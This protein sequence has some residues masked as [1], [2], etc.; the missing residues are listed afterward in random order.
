MTT[1]VSPV[2]K[3]RRIDRIEKAD[4]DEET[5]EKSRWVTAR[6]RCNSY[7]PWEG[8][9]ELLHSMVPYKDYYLSK[10]EKYPSTENVVMN[11][12]FGCTINLGHYLEMFPADFKPS[13][14]AA[15]IAHITDP[16]TACLL[17]H[18]GKAV[19]V[20]A[21]SI[22]S[23][24]LAAQKYRRQLV[25]IGYDTSFKGFLLQNRVC[26][27][28]AGHCIDLEKL[29]KDD[30]VGTVHKWDIFPGVL[31]WINDEDDPRRKIMFLIF[32]SGKFIVTGI[33]HDSEAHRAFD[34]LIPVLHRYYIG[35]AES[36]KKQKGVSK[37]KRL[38]SL[39]IQAIVRA[40]ITHRSSSTL[41]KEQMTEIINEAEKKAIEK[42]KKKKKKEEKEKEKEKEKK[43][44]QTEEEIANEL[45]QEMLSGTT[46]TF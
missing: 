6:H 26:S 9:L 21:K 20:G 43:V 33:R 12:D 46:N 36:R 30:T 27:G 22:D 16:K 28:F 41:T 7:G 34:R 35:Q 5:E 39:R 4:N 24:R 3:R 15:V 17:F 14:F 32:S 1:I 11:V 29:E 10:T 18:T 42:E 38:R 2:T 23:A 37:E 13:Q 8:D 31:Y 45:V 44:P 25:E 19:C 40:T